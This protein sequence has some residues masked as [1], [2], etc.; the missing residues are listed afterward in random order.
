MNF[1]V[2]QKVKITG[3]PWRGYYGKVIRV[4]IEDPYPYKVLIKNL[5]KGVLVSTTPYDEGEMEFAIKIGEQMEFAFMY[6]GVV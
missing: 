2:G 6:E 3:H 5:P 4:C 1:K